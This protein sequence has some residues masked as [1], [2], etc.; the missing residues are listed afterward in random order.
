MK[1]PNPAQRFSSPRSKLRRTQ[2]VRLCRHPRC[3]KIHDSGQNIL[4]ILLFR[5][6]MSTKIAPN[7]MNPGIQNGILMKKSNVR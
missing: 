1:K 4:L 6:S 5:E 2:N 7:K 3:F